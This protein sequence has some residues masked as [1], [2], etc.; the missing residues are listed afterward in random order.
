MVVELLQKQGEASRQD[1]ERLLLSKVS[2]ALDEDQKKNFITN[3]LQ[4]MRRDGVL[5]VEGGRRW[6]KWRLA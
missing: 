4:A 5:T 3:L 6:A 2:D 1:I